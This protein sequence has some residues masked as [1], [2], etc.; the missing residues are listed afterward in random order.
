MSASRS[1][2]ARAA[3]SPSPANGPAAWRS[4]VAPTVLVAD[5][6]HRAHAVHEHEVFGPSTTV[7]PYDS[8]EECVAL[9]ARA[10]GG[11]VSTVYT[12]DRA[13]T[14]EVAL[15]IAAFHGRVCVANGRMGSGWLGPGTVLPGL[16]HGGPGRA[17][18]GEELGGLRGMSLYLQRAALQGFGPLIEHAVSGSKRV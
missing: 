16:L 14:V 1:I 5:D 9:V 10:G 12:D 13:V 17:G 11:L 15:G 18:G 4:S 6:A 2:A 7:L 3:S 8:A